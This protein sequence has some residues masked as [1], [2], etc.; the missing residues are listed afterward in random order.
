VKS[1]RAS[2]ADWVSVPTPPLLLDGEIHVWKAD[3]S[4]S[5]A[6]LGG[7]E[8]RLSEDEQDRAGRFHFAKD[9]GSYVVARAVLRTL[10]GSYLDTAAESLVFDY[11]PQGKPCL[12]PQTA[13]DPISFNLS[14]SSTLALVALTRG[15]AI[16]VDVELIRERQNWEE[17][18]ERFFTDDEVLALRALPSAAR[19]SEFF[20]F[21]TRKEAYI[22]GRG[23]GLSIPL[24][25][26][27][28]AGGHPG[29]VCADDSMELEEF[30]RWSLH[31]LDPGAGFRGAVAVRAP[32]MRVRTLR[33]PPAGI[34][35][36]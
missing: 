21:W 26:F 24:N 14:H 2:S 7:S 29:P 23:E 6:E 8:S 13:A 12:A 10:L 15:H 11:G 28:V 35:M 36:A 5:E 16:G 18:A 3:L 32:E 17:V 25:R 19:T 20:R 1:P 30:S 34:R 4:V 31:D 27:S 9:R 33:W 22:K